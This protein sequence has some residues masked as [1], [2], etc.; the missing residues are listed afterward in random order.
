MFGPLTEVQVRH[1]QKRAGLAVDGIVGR[2]TW[3]QLVAIAPPRRQRHTRAT[4]RAPIPAAVP[5][6]VGAAATVSPPTPEGVSVATWSLF[7]RFEYVVCKVGDYLGGDLKAQWKAMTSGKGLAILVGTLVVWAGGH[8]FGVSEFTDAFLFGFGLAFL[9]RAAIDA[10]RLLKKFLELTVGASVQSDLDLA[11]RCLSQAVTIIGVV[12]FFFIVAKVG[13]ALR[14][15]FKPPAE[16]T[17]PPVVE[18]VLQTQENVQGTKVVRTIQVL[19]KPTVFRHQIMRGIAKLTL[20][21]IMRSGFLRFSTDRVTA[22][23]GEGV[24]VW[25]AK[26]P[27]EHYYYID[28]EVPAGTAAE[29]LESAAGKWYRL[30][31]P[32][33]DNVPV[34]IVG[35]NFPPEDAAFAE[36][37]KLQGGGGD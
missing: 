14:N 21:N 2:K 27:L 34:R 17:T 15:R 36:Q 7:Q 13:R 32:Q 31:S 25:P 18:R 22:V 16:T 24:Y 10:A 1:F 8:C 19:E 35:H 23:F 12:S 20:G 33:G 37:V 9:G 4:L 28:V 26:T 5:V 11:A 30:V 29:L 3:Y 6:P